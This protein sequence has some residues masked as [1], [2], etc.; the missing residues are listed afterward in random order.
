MGAIDN[1]AR[2]WAAF[3]RLPYPGDKEELR[4]DLIYDISLG[5]TTSLKAL[6]KPQYNELCRSI[7]EML[8]KDN[9]KEIYLKERRRLRSACLHQMQ[10]LGVNTADWGAVNSFCLSP[11]ICAK[12]FSQL[13]IDDLKK[14]KR[15][16]HSISSKGNSRQPRKIEK[17]KEVKSYIIVMK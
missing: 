8:P 13:S 5:Q 6:T 2:F 10:L 4:K 1:Y 15:Q 16:L 3:N 11:K 14:L 7:E 9:A 17:T 12:P